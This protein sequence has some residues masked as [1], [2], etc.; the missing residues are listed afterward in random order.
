MLE[1]DSSMLAKLHGESQPKLL[2]S[3]HIHWHMPESDWTD[4]DTVSQQRLSSHRRGAS[5]RNCL[6]PGAP[7]PQRGSYPSAHSGL[8][9]ISGSA[10]LVLQVTSIAPALIL[11]A[12]TPQIL[13]QPR[14]AAR[15]LHRAPGP[16]LQSEAATGHWHLRGDGRTPFS[17]SLAWLHAAFLTIVLCFLSFIIKITFV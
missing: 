13:S 7:V 12:L 10:G 14:E 16:A 4:V 2:E 6:W 15:L 1:R 8:A 17:S 3:W 11:Q 5:G 9:L